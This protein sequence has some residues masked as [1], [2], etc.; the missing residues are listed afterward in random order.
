[1]F[2]KY[3]R[4]KAVILFWMQLETHTV[5]ILDRH[6]IYNNMIPCKFCCERI[7][8][9]LSTNTVILWIRVSERMKWTSLTKNQ[10]QY[11]SSLLQESKWEKESRQFKP[12]KTA[13]SF[14]PLEDVNYS[15]TIMWLCDAVFK[16]LLSYDIY[17]YGNVLGTWYMNLINQTSYW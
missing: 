9:A 8:I 11:T 2:L 6:T 4:F 3:N 14:L 16:Y 17:I 13:S 15:L 5:K 12:L 10:R 1:M 7:V